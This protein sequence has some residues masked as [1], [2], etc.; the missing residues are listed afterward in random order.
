M[1]LRELT[2]PYTMSRY[3]NAANALPSQPYDEPKA[4]DLIRG[5]E[6]ILGWV[7]RNKSIEPITEQR[8]QILLYLDELAPPPIFLE[9]ASRSNVDL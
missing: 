7:E 1:D 2:I 4:K 6:R 5:A 3:P 9:H 8:I